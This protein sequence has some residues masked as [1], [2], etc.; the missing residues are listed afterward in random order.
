MKRLVLL[1]LLPLVACEIE[2]PCPEGQSY[3]SNP[4]EYTWGYN[5][6]SGEY[7]WYWDHSTGGECR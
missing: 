5:V 7:E 4:S 6:L 3:H 2:P 1:L